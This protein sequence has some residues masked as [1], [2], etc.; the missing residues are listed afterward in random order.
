MPKKRSSFGQLSTK[1]IA[2]MGG[3][4]VLTII[5]IVII[6]AVIKNKPQTTSG[7]GQPGSRQ[8]DPV[9]P[10]PVKPGPVQPGPVQPGP[11]QPGPVQPGPVQPGPGIKNNLTTLTKWTTSYNGIDVSKKIYN[12]SKFLQLQQFGN[13]GK[14]L[15]ISKTPGYVGNLFLMDDFNA[16]NNK[17][18]NQGQDA[19]VDINEYTDKNKNVFYLAA[20]ANGGGYW[21]A[22]ITQFTKPN[23]AGG[24]MT[25]LLYSQFHNDGT[26]C[27]IAGGSYFVSNGD[28]RTITTGYT[29][30]DGLK[31]GN[32]VYYDKMIELNDGR[33]LLATYGKQLFISPT[34]K[35]TD[36]KQIKEIPAPPL[37][38]INIFSNLTQLKDGSVVTISNMGNIYIKSATDLINNS[39]N[40]TQ[41]SSVDSL[42]TLTVQ[43]VELSDGTILSVG[44]DG[45]L[46]FLS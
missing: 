34:M 13:K 17:I 8:P 37:F 27:C 6:I 23:T 21:N 39:V 10:G 28:I 29:E 33:M 45:F 4:G 46:Y 44:R 14:N 32:I 1:S 7:P 43:I 41:I 3:I 16:T 5:G 18:I 19:L 24:G 9:K 40:W 42:P 30:V 38:L 31:M 22:D 25:Q 11:V 20:G 26:C 15:V 35:N 12:V 2:I 36:N